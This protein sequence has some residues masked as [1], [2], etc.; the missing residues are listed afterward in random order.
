MQKF[1]ISLQKQFLVS[2]LCSYIHCQ[3]DGIQ[4]ICKIKETR[5]PSANMKFKKISNSNTE[6]QR[7]VTGDHSSI[8]FLLPVINAHYQG[9]MSTAALEGTMSCRSSRQQGCVYWELGNHRLV[10]DGR[11]LMMPVC[12][13]P[14]LPFLCSLYPSHMYFSSVFRASFPSN[15]PWPFPRQ[16]DKTDSRTPS[17]GGYKAPVLSWF[18]LKQEQLFK[19]HFH[20][21]S[22]YQRR[23][24][25]EDA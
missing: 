18:S 17:P 8:F 14:F 22:S 20:K 6:C 13:L 3:E 25:R 21:Y 12:F 5:Q 7:S 10:W 16:K 9:S 4:V 19:T 23:D 11:H 1:Q 15:F 2:N 24:S